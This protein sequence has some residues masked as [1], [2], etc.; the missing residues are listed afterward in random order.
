MIATCQPF[1][2]GAAEE[3]LQIVARATCDCPGESRAQLESRTNQMVHATMGMEPRDG[4]EYMVS[5][6]LFGHFNLILDSMRDVFQGQTDSMKAKTKSGIVALD[7]AMLTLVKELREAKQRPVA[8]YTEDAKQADAPPPPAEATIPNEPEELVP[9][10]CQPEETVPPPES[11]EY[12]P[13][14]AIPPRDTA[15]IVPEDDWL[16]EAVAAFVD[17]LAADQESLAGGDGAKPRPVATGD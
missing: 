2:R 6:L 3:M 7:R 15:S 16:K 17:A 13:A 5:A 8:K 10:M 4:L 12:P 9:E 14:T 11:I 1:P